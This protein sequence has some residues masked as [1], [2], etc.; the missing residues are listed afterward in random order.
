MGCPRRLCLANRA[1]IYD[2][3]FY[4]DQRMILA[5]LSHLS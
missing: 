3:K 5:T 2:F 1:R 4:V